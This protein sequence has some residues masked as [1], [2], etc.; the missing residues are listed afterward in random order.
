MQVGADHAAIQH[1][2]VSISSVV[3]GAGHHGIAERGG[4]GSQMRAA[5][6]VL[7][8][9]QGV[10]AQF[11][12]HGNVT[13]QAP[14]A[15]RGL[16]IEHAKAL[17]A[18]VAHVIG[19]A[20]Q[21]VAAAN[22]QQCSVRLD[23]AR[24]LLAARCEL[25][26]NGQLIAVGAAAH[27]D[28]VGAFEVELLTHGDLVDRDGDAAPRAA[29]FDDHRVSAVAIQVEGIGIQ[30]HHAQRSLE[31]QLLVER[32]ERLDALCRLGRERTLRLKLL[33]LLHQRGE[34][35]VVRHRIERL[36][37]VLLRHRGKCRGDAADDLG[38]DAGIFKTD[39]HVVSARSAGKGNQP[40]RVGDAF[41]VHIPDPGH[42]VS[43]GI[44]VVEEERGEGAPGGFDLLDL[45]VEAHGVLCQVAYDLAPGH[46]PRCHAPA[47]GNVRI[48]HMLELLG[49]G[50]QLL[51]GKER[52]RHVVDHV[53]TVV[54][55]IDMRYL[56][57]FAGCIE[58]IALGRESHPA[59]R[60]R[61]L[62]AA[63]SALGACVRAELPVLHKGVIER[64]AALGAEARL[65]DTGGFGARGLGEAE[66]DRGV[67][68]AIGDGG[69]KRVIG[70][71]DERGEPGG[72]ERLDDNVLRVVDFSAAVQLVAEQVE[73]YEEARLE[74]GQDARGVQLVAL[75]H[76][77]A[78][79]VALMFDAAVRFQQRA[80]DTG[81][82][83]VA[84]A[85]ANGDGPAGRHRVG[86][87]V[88]GR[89]LAVGA[90]NDHAFVEH[91][92]ERAQQLGVD[93]HGDGA[94]QDASIAM[95]DR[96]QAP[97]GEACG[98]GCK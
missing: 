73:Q 70:V 6:M 91:A 52:G 43:V 98:G 54:R 94:G 22:R 80:H 74:L 24:Y 45:A 8:S 13:D 72:F 44:V 66:R 19:V 29:A 39:L 81:L 89:R 65:G 85:I 36:I 17:D 83:V 31:L 96:A 78:R 60:S 21:L 75:E 84:R 63:P 32:A 67:W 3:A 68:H 92:A 34:R 95:E 62:G 33:E 61:Q 2:F 55:G 16:D 7:K 88:R 87:E 59:H 76:A 42:V 26:R 38:I 5:A 64:G 86:D 71:E 79:G 46:I 4:V 77:D 10:I 9:H 30:V 35:R 53:Q 40:R 28:D 12:C 57:V 49:M 25:V 37:D 56:L 20:Q 90:G 14:L 69:A 82:H 51:G 27:K 48:E 93:L 97:T 15:A 58:G 11:G 23:I 18:R 41:E 47:C 50:A 1:A